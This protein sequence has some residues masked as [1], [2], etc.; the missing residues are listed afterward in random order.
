MDGGKK[1]MGWWV[2]GWQV[3]KKRDGG[4][5]KLDGRRSGLNAGGSELGKEA[6]RSRCDGDG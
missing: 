2:S 5:G 6:R 4:D 3:G 1:R